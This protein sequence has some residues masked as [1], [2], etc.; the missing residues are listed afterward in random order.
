[1]LKNKAGESPSF[2]AVVSDLVREDGV[3]GFYRGFVPRWASVSLWG[4]CMVTTYEFLSKC[5][6]IIFSHLLWA[7]WYNFY[8]VG[9]ALGC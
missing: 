2:R 4:T 1:M 7:Y 9:R 5:L 8:C 3:R 6:F